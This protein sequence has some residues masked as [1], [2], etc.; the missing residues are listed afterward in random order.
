M[1]GAVR[2]K[3]RWKG[4]RAPTQDP[5]TNH[6]LSRTGENFGPVSSMN[7]V[8]FGA[9]GRV[10][11]GCVCNVLNSTTNWVRCVVGPRVIAGT[12]GVRV[13]VHPWGTSA[14]NASFTLVPS[15]RPVQPKA[16]SRPGLCGAHS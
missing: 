4:R 9:R 10:C 11:T 7:S 15:I 2:N 5:S 12:H 14:A 13:V 3:E 16:L 1:R 8:V 6:L